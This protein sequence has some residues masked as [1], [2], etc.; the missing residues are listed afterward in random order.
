MKET[1]LRNTPPDVRANFLAYLNE[2]PFT[3]EHRPPLYGEAIP[4][5]EAL[6][7]QKTE[8]LLQETQS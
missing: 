4:G 5:Y 7:R 3:A 2:I 8:T 1:S 6:I